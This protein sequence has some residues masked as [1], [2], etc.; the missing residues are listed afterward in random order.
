MTSSMTTTTEKLT[1]LYKTRI[2]LDNKLRLQKETFNR[3]DS[4]LHFAALKQTRDELRVNQAE[5]DVLL[6]SSQ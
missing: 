2:F 6:D 4:D 1:A 3:T 5:I